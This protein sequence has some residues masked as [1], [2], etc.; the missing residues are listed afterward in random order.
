MEEAHALFDLSIEKN[1]LS[2]R[3]KAVC[4]D[5][6]Q[7]KSVPELVCGGFDLVVCNPP[8]FESGY[9]GGARQ[10]ARQETELDIF[11][12]CRAAAYALKY[13]GRLCVCFKPQR[14]AD[15]LEAMRQSKIEPKT[16]RLVLSKEDEAP[17]LVLVEGKRGA[18]PQLNWK[19]A[20]ILRNPD[21]SFTE[22]Y[23]DIYR[24]R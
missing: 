18:N 19:P 7:Y 4:C 3:V 1:S 16:I 22:E 15:L 10:I 24:M 12:V 20:L 2:D 9:G 23:R 13:G 6:N 5:L 14:L 8:Y 17:Y 21:G 11:A